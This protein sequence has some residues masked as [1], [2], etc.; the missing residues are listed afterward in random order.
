MRVLS[1]QGR[2]AADHTSSQ[3][4][5][6]RAHFLNEGAVAERSLETPA[7]V[8]FDRADFLAVMPGACTFAR[9]PH[10]RIPN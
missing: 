6:I 3:T 1:A 7:R 8:P 2:I 5:S 4:K 9:V 10:G